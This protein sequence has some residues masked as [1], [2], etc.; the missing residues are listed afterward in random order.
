MPEILDHIA[1][2]SQEVGPRP[3]GT[4]EEQ[5]AALYIAEYLQKEAGLSAVVEDFN[6]ESNEEAPKAIF[7]LFTLLITIPA[8][9]FPILAIPSLVVTAIMA[10]LFILE[11][12][13][14]PFI[15]NRL[16]RGVSQNVIARYE[17]G[18]SPESGGARRRKIVLVAHYDSGKVRPE[19]R[20]P[21]LDILPQMQRLVLYTMVFIPVFLFIR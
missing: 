1:F 6:S 4:E 11:S 5:Q 10:V 20:E 18:Y 17:P 15:L 12:L 14:R 19:L 9:F 3:A 21:F 7:A 8:I 2:L 13:D 16:A